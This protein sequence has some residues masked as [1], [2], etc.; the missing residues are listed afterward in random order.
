M[1]RAGGRVEDSRASLN[2]LELIL[3]TFGTFYFFIFFRSEI[4]ISF[5]GLC[6]GQRRPGGAE[7]RRQSEDRAGSRGEGGGRR[8]TRAGGSVGVAQRR[9]KAW[10]V[11]LSDLQR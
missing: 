5:L 8:V 10:G 6:M 3:D 9:G 11:P 7:G 1:T 4:L 2:T